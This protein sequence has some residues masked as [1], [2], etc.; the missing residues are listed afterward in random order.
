MHI[1]AWIAQKEDA[2]APITDNSI[3]LLQQAFKEH[4]SPNSEAITDI[5]QKHHPGAHITKTV[6][7]GSPVWSTNPYATADSFFFAATASPAVLSGA[8]A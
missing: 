6:L 7:Y 5:C 8:T 3:G 1:P 2:P 4:S